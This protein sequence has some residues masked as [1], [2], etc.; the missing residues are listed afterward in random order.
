[1]KAAL[2]ICLCMISMTFCF[3]KQLHVGKAHHF[4]EIKAAVASAQPHDT[5]YI[6]AGH[7][8]EHTIILDK[9]I[10]LIGINKPVIDAEKLQKELI[11]IAADSVMVE[12]LVLANVGVSFLNELSAIK[13]KNGKFGIIRNN[14]IRACFFGIYL[15][16]ASD[17]EVTNNQILGEAEDEA[18]AGNAIHV[19]KAKRIEVAHNTVTGHRDG[20]YFEF[21]DNS[22][23]HNNVS[24]DNIR[25]GLHFMFSN[26]DKYHQNSFKNNGAGVAVM[27]SRHINMTNNK[28][29]NNRGGASYGL[30]LKEISD[31]SISQNEFHK[32]TVGILAEGANRLTISQNE[33]TLN[34][35]A[36]DIKG[37]CL[38][39]IITKN[40]F[41]ANTF[42]VVTNTKQN[43]NEYDLNYWS[44][45]SGYDLNRDGIG[46]EPYRPVSLY[47]K[48]TSEIPAA[49]LLL[50]SFVV[51]LIEFTERVVPQIIPAELIDKHPKMQPFDYD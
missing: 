12:G 23:I 44:S 31:G 42:E 17:F 45:Y 15:G 29:I 20:I 32:N 2:S 8:N 10:K 11:I 19:W 50:H 48:I 39:N 34:G 3:G 21:V 33:F 6:H 27:F 38:D 16:Y 26:Y 24:R 46:D 37:N 49:S 28:F 1:M 9:P 43:K 7:Y 5:V 25:Y 41:T 35:T 13:V 47:A 18:S 36:L 51:N 4:K 14:E 22:N 30:L 40:N